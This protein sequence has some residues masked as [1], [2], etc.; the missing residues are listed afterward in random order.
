MS[1]RA[2]FFG[3]PEFAIPTLQALVQSPDIDVLAVV[4]RPDK[5][6]G[7]G[8][9]L[10]SPPVKLTAQELGIECYQPVSLKSNEVVEWLQAK[11]ADVF[12]VVAYGG[13]IPTPVREIPPFECI[14]LHPSLLPKYR[15]AAPIQAAIINGDEKTGNTTMY[16]S[17]GWDN[18]DI[19]HQEEEPIRPDDSYG[20]LSERLAKKGAP[21]VLRTVIDVANGSAP[22]IP[23]REEE[24]TF[25]KMIENDDAHIDWTRPAREIQDRKSVV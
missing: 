21:L 6:A 15:G 3:T 25:A 14:N 17:D 13:F 12:V 20:A 1:I 24:A 18:G 2:I 7:R 4:T 22:R 8:K 16:L 10:Q 11:R 5:P 19:I 9:K 23:Q